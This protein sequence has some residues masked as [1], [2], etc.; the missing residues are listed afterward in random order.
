[1]KRHALVPKNVYQ[2]IFK[3]PSM[4]KKVISTWQVLGAERTLENIVL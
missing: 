2:E 4:L 1:M 3:F